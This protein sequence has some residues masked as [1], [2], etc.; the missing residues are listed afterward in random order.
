[1]P[2]WHDVTA[3]LRREQAITVIGITQEQH[4]E[5]CLLFA[6][7]QAF[8]WP[9][10]W[11]PFNLTGAT[12]VPG[13]YAVDEYGIIRHSRLDPRRVDEQLIGEFIV[14]EFDPPTTERPVVFARS[15]DSD[16]RDRRSRAYSAFLWNAAGT[17]QAPLEGLEKLGLD[18]E[19][20]DPADLF[21]GGVAYR[22]R[23]DSPFAEPS[24]FQRA[25]DLWGAALARDPNQYIWRRRIQQYGPR[26]DK[27]YPFYDWIERAQVDVEKR[28]EEPVA[29]A[30][31]LSGAELA[32]P[33]NQLPSP[34][35]GEVAPDPKGTIA[36]DEEHFIRVEGAA[37]VHTAAYGARVR[38][39]SSARVHVAL[40]PD[41]ER[42]VHWTNDAGETVVWIDVPAGWRI[43]RQL[44]TLEAPP[45]ASSSETRRLDFEL[46][47]P[48]E[49][50][51]PAKVH[52][53]ALYYICEGESGAC[54][55]R[56]QNFVIPVGG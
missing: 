8:D 49:W 53:Y 18:P 26:L 30:V 23:Y 33:S 4:P 56:R 55:Y 6:Q 20:S 48:E 46:S 37:A 41:A 3:E 35:E 24:D 13:V 14:G 25:L 27:P 51:G 32:R 16:A 9:I 54:L 10:L 11:D 12:A 38:Q 28:G 52:G 39:R 36:L 2:V 50:S 21:R 43:E 17:M 42:D 47:P 44:Y 45:K 31:P 15:G 22:M 40:K 7:W 29:L 5:R 34:E 19:T 1:M